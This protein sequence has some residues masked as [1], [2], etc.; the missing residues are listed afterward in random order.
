LLDPVLQ[1]GDS[2]ALVAQ[3]L[4]PAGRAR[5]LMRLDGEQYPGN[6]GSGGG[7][8]ADGSGE[9][10]LGPVG[11]RDD[12]RVRPRPAAQLDRVSGALGGGGE[13]RAD[14]ARSD[15]GDPGHPGSSISPA[16]R[17]SLF[18]SSCDPAFLRMFAPGQS[19]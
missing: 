19:S 4:Q 2:R 14:R 3:R 15:D 18:E 1:H 11:Q 6:G 12:G 8:V 13:R 9:R 5:G 7:I 10:M 16:P 17:E